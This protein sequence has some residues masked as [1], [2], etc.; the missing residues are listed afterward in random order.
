MNRKLRRA[1]AKLGQTSRHPPAETAAARVPAGAAD[2][3]A[4]GLEH[5]RAGR[6]AEAEVW[7]RRVLVAQPN[8]ADALHLLGVVAHQ[9]GRHDLA[10]E[11][12]RQAIQQ[13]GQPSYFFNLGKVF[14]SHGKLNEAVAAYRQAISV[15]PDFAEAHSNLG[16]ALSEQSR[17]DEAVAAYRQA[18]SIKPDY[19]EAHSNL[20]V[21]LN[22]QGKLDEAI[23]AYRQAVRIKPDYAEIHC[24][25]GNALKERGKLDE[26]IAAYRQAVRIKP[27]YAEAHSN[28][29]VALNQQGKLDEAIAAYRQAVRIKPDYAETYCNLGNALKERGKLGEAI[30]VYRQAVHIKPDHAEAH[31]SLGVALKE[32]GKVDEAIAAYRQA[33]SI[34]P[35]Y[36]EAHS[37]LGNAL[38]ERGSLDEAIA[39]YRQA[40]RVKPDFAEAHY[41]LSDALKG[42]G[43][44]DEAIAAYCQAISV[45]PDF[46]EAHSN[47]GNAL[48]ER[49]SLDEAVGA[50]RQAIRIKPDFAE[51]HYNLGVA[52]KEQGKVDEAIAAYRQAITVKPDYPEAHSNLGV[53]LKEQG[54]VD[55]AIAAYR[56]AISI[57]P[58]YAKA[59]C[60]LGVALNERGELGEAIAAYRQ[61]ISIKPDYAEAHSNLG[62]ALKER[63]GL[64]EAIA[65]YRQAISIKPDFLEAHYNLG[66]ALKER[67]KFNEAIAAYRQAARIKPDFAEAH[68]NLSVALKEQGKLDEAIATFRQAISIKPDLAEVH[69]NLMMCLHYS[70]SVGNADVHAE[71]LE[72][73]RRYDAGVGTAPHNNVRDPHRRLRIG[74]VSADFRYHPVGYFLSS[75]LSAHDHAVTEIYCYS[76]QVTDDD[77]TVRLRACADQWRSISSV[78][79]IDAAALIRRDAIDI[80]VD[81]SGHTA[82][83]RLTMFALRPAPV[84][85]SW[86]GYFGTT[87]LSSIDYILADRFI[88][89][90]GEQKYFTEAVWHLPGS[91]LCYAPHDFDV[92]V[93]LPPA[94]NDGNVTFGCFNNR[95]KITANTVSIWASILRRLDGSRLFLKNKSLA[96]TVVGETLVA[97]F[98]AHGIAPDR[99]ILEGHS[100]LAEALEA[101]NRVD[102][103]LDPF[104][105]G[106]GT[107]TAQTIWMGV[108]VVTLRGDR[109]VGRM[110]ESI[111]S[112]VGLPELV[113]ANEIEYVEI[114]L[115]LAADL[116]GL[117]E[118]RSA[119]RSL[120]EG[121]A[122]CNGVGFTRQ[123][124][125]AFRGMWNAWCRR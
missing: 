58:D 124:E 27:D 116:P 37:N 9:L 66:N 54:K 53:A 102:I 59:L 69:S 40:I 109:W 23:A 118:R 94:L 77:M 42:R 115:R 73:G 45:K 63:G 78:P 84:Q 38:K 1:A 22:E 74:Y 120:V 19:A 44:L 87:G 16:N 92:R 103:A 15:K 14:F 2:L 41:N 68:S 79:D 20:G 71:A 100:P 5:H 75:V 24:N 122:F 6:L 17:F 26:A 13:N 62:N 117:A 86:L 113:A 61:A 3:L 25:L 52:L 32:R 101:Y 55:E 97:Q 64:D 33:I 91:Y 93:A 18:I 67:G 112:A 106:G 119:L 81:L 8:H 65:A 48:K 51:A 88:V 35:S 60:N 107:T 121:S 28:L 50:Y 10:V 90:E 114:A 49:G 99:L 104:P 31:F 56:Q 30:A 39:A 43:K 29:G 105:F 111:L 98:A 89:P 110:S 108:P 12:I 4:A 76:N 7:Y 83:N 57:K 96:D 70:S 36:A 11:L 80:L 82:G 123:L 72:F 34:K 95:A 125:A 47:L 85:V 46:A 21:V